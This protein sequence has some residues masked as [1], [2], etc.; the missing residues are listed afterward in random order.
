MMPGWLRPFLPHIAAVAA[1]LSVMWW[2]DHRG[3]SRAKEDMAAQAARI[4]N[5]VRAEL[6]AAETRLTDQMAANDRA[7][8]G[9]IAAIDAVHRTVIQPTIM[10]ELTREKRFTDPASGIPDSVRGEVNRAIAA[11]ACTATAD[12]GISCPLPAAAPAGE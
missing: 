7:V 12:G 4:E 2:L 9:Q 1:I 8:A 6:R 10:R 3:Y 5:R 11:V